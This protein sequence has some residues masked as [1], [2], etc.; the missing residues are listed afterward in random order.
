M[1]LLIV[2]PVLIP[3][4]TGATTLVA[5]RSYRA[6]RVIPVAGGVGLLAAG[7]ALLFDVGVYLVVVGVTLL[8]VLT[9]VED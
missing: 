7:I 1:S 3:L 5:W 4:A 8:I 2:L 6:Q 9:L